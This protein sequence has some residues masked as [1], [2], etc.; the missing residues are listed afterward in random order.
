[1]GLVEGF[2]I[3]DL[4]GVGEGNNLYPG[5]QYFD[6]L[7]LADDPVTFAE[8]KV[9]EIKPCSPCLV[10]LFKPLLREKVP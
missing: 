10:S 9:K 7:G 5:G 4:L 8:L 1:M 2:Y 6:P 3:N